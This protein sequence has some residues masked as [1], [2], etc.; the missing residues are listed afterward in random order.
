MAAFD[1]IRF[2]RPS[3]R[4]TLGVRPLRLPLR[5]VVAVDTV[6]AIFS[7]FPFETLFAFFA[8][9]AAV[10]HSPFARLYHQAGDSNRDPGDARDD[11]HHRKH[12][13]ARDKKSDERTKPI[14]SRPSP[15]S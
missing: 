11:A 13:L 6:F 5:H 9:L 4:C 1:F 10:A 14:S 2:R 8:F 3:G 15:K 7:L 12:R